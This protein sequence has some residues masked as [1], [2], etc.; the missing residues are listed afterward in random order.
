MAD[1]INLIERKI[2]DQL[3]ADFPT[4]HVFGQYPEAVDVQYPAIILE[5]EG[6]GPYQKMMGEKVSFGATD[7]TGEIYGIIYIV[8][9][10]INEEISITVGSDKYKQRRLMNYLMLNVA[11]TMT[12][13]GTTAKPWP[14]TVD[15]IEQEWKRQHKGSI[16]ARG[17]VGG[18]GRWYTR[19]RN[20]PPQTVDK[21][22]TYKDYSHF[23]GENLNWKGNSQRYKR[24]GHIRRK[25]ETPQDLISGNVP[26]VKETARMKEFSA[27]RKHATS[28]RQ[29]TPLGMK[30]RWIRGG[31]PKGGQHL[32]NFKLTNKR[33]LKTGTYEGDVD[34]LPE[35]HIMNHWFRLWEQNYNLYLRGES[36]RVLRHFL[37]LMEAPEIGSKVVKPKVT[38][39][40][41]VVF[42]GPRQKRGKARAPRTYATK[43]LVQ[44]YSRKFGVAGLAS[45][46][47][48]EGILKDGFHFMG[49]EKT[50]DVSSSL[51]EKIAMSSTNDINKFITDVSAL[52]RKL[53]RTK[54]SRET[55]PRANKMIG[56]P[57]GN[58]IGI[59]II[60][61]PGPQQAPDPPVKLT[62]TVITTGKRELATVLNSLVQNNV[63]KRRKT[64]QKKIMKDSGAKKLMEAEIEQSLELYYN[65]VG[66][67]ANYQVSM[68]GEKA[69]SAPLG[70]EMARTIRR[71]VAR[72][73]RKDWKDME[74][75]V[76][77]AIS[78]EESGRQSSN[79][80]TWYRYWVRESK[81]IE[82][83]V[84][85]GVR[86]YW[87]KF[88]QTNVARKTNMYRGG[89]IK[90]YL[91]AARTWHSPG[92][93]R[94]FVS[95]DV[96][97]MG[98]GIPQQRRL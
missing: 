29:I 89:K 91:D 46:E 28:N 43:R 77:Q 36:Q 42:G 78:P 32:K 68:Q 66:K 56:M 45:R 80:M 58:Y 70:V 27:K 55:V 83:R 41:K 6:S 18:G 90:S 74:A 22:W 57:L 96:P 4:C 63:T 21:N 2:I 50:S 31:G 26:N 17:N 52:Q 71:R 86:P 10:L 35:N 53:N 49:S 24:G 97:T 54:E 82:R 47:T 14:A 37:K 20:T 33:Q 3:R 34:K 15:V 87:S 94:P 69:A 81:K 7:Y 61:R 25:V 98:T 38:G 64:Q 72:G 95:T 84:V 40:T 8:H 19:G 30:A 88:M 79:F 1:F 75:D 76:R 39:G 92:Y 16:G 44:Q 93:I 51:F 23:T 12:D 62:P 65:I 59:V 67:S 5:I 13:I 60:G 85:A 9:L 48:F 11:N 73:V